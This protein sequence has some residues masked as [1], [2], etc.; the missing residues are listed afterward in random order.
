MPVMRERQVPRYAGGFV[1][2]SN[3]EVA[4]YSDDVRPAYHVECHCRNCSWKGEARIAAG[5][6]I[7]LWLICPKCETQ[8]LSAHGDFVM[9]EE[10][11]VAQ[12]QRDEKKERE[13]RSQLAA[14]MRSS[15][16]AL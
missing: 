6:K 3:N 8:E 12:Q 7:P 1:L 9:R 5:Q 10:R 13:R 14:D 16:R 2:T 15:R 4:D 11:S